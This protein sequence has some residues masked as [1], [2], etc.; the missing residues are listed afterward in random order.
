MRTGLGEFSLDL[1]RQNTGPSGNPQ[2]PMDIQ[3]FDTDFSRLGYAYDF[4]NVRLEANV[5]YTDVS[6]LMDNF[7]MRPSPGAMGERATYA[8][9]TT[10]GAEVALGF[11]AFGGELIVGV[12]GETAEHHVTITN[13][14]NASFYVTPFPEIDSDRVGGFAEWNGPLGPVETQL[15]L[16]V[17]RN[18]YDAGTAVV[19]PA[20]P[21]MPG[22][23]AMAFNNADRSGEDITVDAVARVW[24]PAVNGISWRATFARKEQMPG[25]IQRYGW[26]PIN[27]SGGLADGNT[28]VGD[29]TLDPETAWIAE[30]GFDFAS[31]NAY[32]RPT[33]FYRRVD[34]YIQ[35][36]PYDSTI[37]VADTPVEMVAS[38]NGD[39]TPLRWDNVDAR[40][41]GFDVDGGYDFAGP[42]R[43]D[44]VFSYVRGERRDID[45]NLYR[46]AP[47]SLTVGL[48]WE[49]AVWSATL[50]ARGVAEQDDV[51][52]TNSE[53]RTGA[54]ALLSAY[55]EWQVHDGVRL[56]AGVENIFDTVYEN[57]L[58]GYNRN[59]FG[60]APV[61][62]RVPG[63]GRGVFVRLSLSR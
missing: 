31:G 11:D 17:D 26:L 6:H 50:E 48:T 37:G 54:Y 52:V 35:G 23:L 2:F 12:D 1:R 56:S 58:A 43:I 21:A 55:G 8:D 7:S 28:Y 22:M 33:I 49:A 16:R 3:Y 44:G 59:G 53:A 5:H 47:P 57:H 25:Y 51:S 15:G 42:L 4:G 34:N 20:L 24:T 61:G 9:A 27:A 14:N 18:R 62:E 19:G 32:L 13:P 36:V 38:M 46:V 10:Q 30:A 45:D 63:A 41:Y 39:P 60:D 40:L 29:L